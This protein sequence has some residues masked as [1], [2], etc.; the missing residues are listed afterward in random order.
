MIL[1]MSEVQEGHRRIQAEKLVEKE[2]ETIPN[3]DS[4]IKEDF[5]E[6]VTPKL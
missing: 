2:R 1:H 4:D 6:E 3:L 5:L